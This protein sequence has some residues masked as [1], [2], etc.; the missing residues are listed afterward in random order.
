[1]DSRPKL[2]IIQIPDISVSSLISVLPTA[3]VA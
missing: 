3:P 2:P 1:M